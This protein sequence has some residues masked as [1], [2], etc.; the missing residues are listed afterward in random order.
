ME[1]NIII[2]DIVRTLDNIREWTT[3]QNVPKNLLNKFNSVYLKPEPYGVVLCIGPWNYPVQLILLPLV[4]IIAAG[5]DFETK[6][7]VSSFL[8]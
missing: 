4:G 8:S 3:P 2:G 5:G 7:T 1:Y 6:E